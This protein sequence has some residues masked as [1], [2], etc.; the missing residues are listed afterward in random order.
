MH[1]FASSFSIVFLHNSSKS[2][3]SRIVIFILFHKTFFLVKYC[4]EKSRENAGGYKLRPVF[5]LPLTQACT[6]F[7]SHKL[8]LKYDMLTGLG[9]IQVLRHHV[10]DFLWFLMIYSTV[11]H[12]R[13]PFSDPTHPPLWWRNTWMPP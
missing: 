11:N 1:M 12:Q 9:G 10:F 5:R 3:W 4:V 2:L 7:I 6:N 8:S 13:L